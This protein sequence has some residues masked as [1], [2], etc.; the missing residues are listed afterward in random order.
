MSLSATSTD[1]WTSQRQ[2]RTAFA[3][4]M[5]DAPATRAEFTASIDRCVHALIC[6]APVP[7]ALIQLRRWLCDDAV[8]LA[9]GTPVDFTLFDDA[10]LSID[11]RIAQTG[12]R[13]QVQLL[14]ASRR[15]AESIYAKT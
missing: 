11:E 12:A 6:A 3:A 7:T 15:L 2:S 1:D 5:A 14:H 10:I 13:S 8:T 9:D 4:R